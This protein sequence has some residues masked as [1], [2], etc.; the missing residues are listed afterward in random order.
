M[1]LIVPEPG[2]LE[3]TKWNKKRGQYFHAIHTL[4]SEKYNIPL[5][6]ISEIRKFAIHRKL[7]K[8]EICIEITKNFNEGN[9]NR[10]PGKCKHP[11]GFSSFSKLR[12]V[13]EEMLKTLLKM[14]PE[15]F[16]DIT[17][18]KKYDWDFVNSGT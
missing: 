16:T 6:I 15:T 8:K 5:L 14:T 13:R 10:E 18:L 11:K 4:Y 3:R 2:T 1:T 12:E 9:Y 17:Q 7:T